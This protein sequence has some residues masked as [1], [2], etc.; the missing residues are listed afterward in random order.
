MLFNRNSAIQRASRRFCTVYKSEN[1]VPC[2][3]SGRRDIPSGR[4]TVQRI[5]I[6]DDENFPTGPSSVSRSFELLQLASIWTF[7]QYVRTTLSVRHASGFLSKTQLWEVRSFER[8]VSH[9]NLD[10]QT[11]VH[12]ILKLRASE[13]QSGRPF[14]WSGRQGTTVWT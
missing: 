3:P 5:I 4:P 10:V 12:Q 9:S 6:P 13:Q 7:Q 2:Q 1:L 11:R 14:P 8:Q